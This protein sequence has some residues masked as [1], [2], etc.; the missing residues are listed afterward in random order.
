MNL[1]ASCTHP[2]NETFFFP[3]APRCKSNQKFVY[4]SDVEEKIRILCDVDA[5]PVP[6]RFH[7]SIQTNHSSVRHPLQQFHSSGARSSA[8]YT[9]TGRDQLGDVYCSAENAVGLQVN[10]C[11]FHVVAAGKFVS[12][13]WK[14]I[15]LT[16]A[17]RWSPWQ[18]LNKLKR[19]LFMVS[20][21]R[22]F[23]YSEVSQ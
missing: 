9:P 7:W 13:R 20:I 2:T 23:T 8:L 4:G 21:Q 19:L 16:I 17:G 22:T 6:I 18:L 14:N 15:Y 10:P 3:D 1:I 12:I 11:I 5:N